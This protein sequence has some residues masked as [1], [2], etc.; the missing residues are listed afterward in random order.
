MLRESSQAIVPDFDHPL[1]LPVVELTLYFGNAL[2]V[3]HMPLVKLAQALLVVCA[4]FLILNAFS[5]QLVHRWTPEDESK[6]LVVTDEALLRIFS[7]DLPAC[8]LG[9]YTFEDKL[10]LDDE[11]LSLGNRHVDSV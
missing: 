10:T 1:G 3:V 4:N 8:A 9:F 6:H 5:G 2:H 7:Q 11:T